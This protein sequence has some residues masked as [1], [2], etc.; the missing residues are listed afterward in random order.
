MPNNKSGLGGSLDVLKPVSGVS[1]SG[2]PQRVVEDFAK[3]H[4]GFVPPGSDVGSY[5]S[6]GS[7]SATGTG[8]VGGT[9]VDGG[10]AVGQFG[11][12]GSGVFGG[13]AAVGQPGVLTGGTVSKGVGG[14]VPNGGVQGGLIAGG[15]GGVVQPGV[16]QPVNYVGSADGFIRGRFDLPPAVRRP[17]GSVAV[18]AGD[19]YAMP[20]VGSGAGGLGTG[21]GVGSGTG[22][23]GEMNG[24]SVKGVSLS[25]V[26]SGGVQGSAGFRG[27]PGKRD[28]GF[29]GWLGGLLPKV[30][31]GQREGESDDEY[32]RRMTRNREKY[33][34][35]ADALRHIGN[36]VNTSGYAP[37][38]QLNDP[39]GMLE[40]GYQL[41]RQQRQQQESVDREA[42][43][44]D[45]ELR[46]R[47]RNAESD[48]A[49]KAL[50][51]QLQKNSADLDRA[52]FEWQ[53]AKYDSDLGYK[54]E[55]DKRNEAYR[56]RKFAADQHQR[57]V[58]NGL[59]AQQV[60]KSGKVGSGTS[61]GKDY[62]YFEG[63]DGKMHYQHNKTMFEQEFFKEYGQSPYSAQSSS[64]ST[65]SIDP[66]TGS[67]TTTTTRKRGESLTAFAARQQNEAKARRE[68]EAKRKADEAKAKKAVASGKGT[69]KGSGKSSSKGSFVSASKDRGN[70]ASNGKYKG[71][72][73]HV[74]ALGL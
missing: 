45:S 16:V 13:N 18:D 64:T 5:G 53:K 39:V 49:Y 63:K 9:A 74:A 67:E 40:Q 58:S 62:Y 52:K 8:L 68:A 34:L 22:V 66:K 12:A 15:Q 73:S 20:Y 72:F 14:V 71:K 27:D 29:F 30:R 25:D 41:R 60:A 42:A 19:G 50:N 59:R 33:M 10:S 70:G 17:D 48:A 44:R 43:M 54:E 2:I 23:G 11:G 57:D 21:D 47:Q 46:M 69:G 1:V 61:G 24:G 28:G 38:Q 26:L 31:D 6:L 4:P 32:D 7:G 37:S 36:I 3:T 65:K 35:L 56:E 55:K 51:A